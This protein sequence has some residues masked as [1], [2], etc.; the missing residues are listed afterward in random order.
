MFEIQAKSPDAY[1]LAK[2]IGVD[3]L[4]Q[5]KFAGVMAATWMGEMVK[6]A[7]L[8]AVKTVFDRPTKFTI[9]SL[10]L[11]P[12]TKTN[13][14]AI[15]R[16]RDFAAKGTPAAKYLGPQAY[17]GT[18][19]HKRFEMALIHKGAMLS[20]QFAIPT[21]GAPLDQFG[22]VKRSE[23]VKMLSD[24]KAFGQTGYDANRTG[25]RRSRSKAKAS[26]YF[27]AKT[28]AGRP[29][30]VW[31][32]KQSAF[33]EGKKDIF[34]F[35]STAPRYKV[36]L[37]FEDIASATVAKNYDRVFMQALDQALATARRA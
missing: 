4:K 27:I 26:G 21:K 20:S 31:Q 7:E 29:I 30:G 5:T 22:N 24:A 28:K 37:H 36:R 9:N 32:T 33:G 17:G 8:R 3:A 23:I 13:P 1:Q 11:Q 18:R 2:F 15:V 35:V 25:S 14:S 34:K 10:Q 16:F 6:A 19:E 12:A